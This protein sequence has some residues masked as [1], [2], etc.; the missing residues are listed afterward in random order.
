MRYMLRTSIGAV[1]FALITS[2]SP[3]HSGEPPNFIQETFSEDGVDSAW[4]NY[5]SIFLDSNTVLD[6]KT[7]ELMALSVS[8]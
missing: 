7:K 4:A 8:A 3:V 6:G 1:I 2:F 5:Q